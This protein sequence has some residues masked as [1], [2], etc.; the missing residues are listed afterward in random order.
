MKKKQNIIFILSDQHNHSVMS[1]ADDNFINTPNL[2]KLANNGTRFTNAYTNSPLCVPSRMSLLTGKL[3]LENRCLTNEGILDV[4][5]P[6]YAH[7]INSA[8]YET[9]LSGRMHIY[10]CDQYRGN[11]KRLV[12]DTTSLN[13]GYDNISC[14]LGDK[15][16]NSNLQKIECVN[17]SGGGNSVVQE[18]DNLVTKK[19][20]EFLENRTDERPLMLTVGFYAP[21]PPFIADEERF[22]YFYNQLDDSVC[23]D[24]FEENIHPAISEWKRRRGVENITKEEF[25]RMRAAY[26]ANVEMLDKNIGKIIDKAIETLDNTVF[27]YT[28]D[29]GDSMGIN[30]MLWKTTFFDSSVKIPMI[31]SGNGINN[32]LVNEPV[33]LA[34]ITSTLIDLAGA[35]EL[36]ETYGISLKEVLSSSKKLNKN[37]SIISQ[38]GTYG[39]NTNDLDMPSA[40]IQKNGFKLISFYGYKRVLLYNT[41]NDINCS[42]DLSSK[43]EYKQIKLDLL[44]ELNQHWNEEEALNISKKHLENFTYL[45]EWANSTKFNLIDMYYDGLNEKF[46]RNFRINK[47]SNYINVFSD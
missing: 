17:N 26:Y 10:G 1:C 12:G 29:H 19:T 4:S 37:R 38:L 34:D 8:G 23:D 3:P 25:K 33:C 2:D 42:N 15:F 39:K 27:I 36:P 32:G 45:K 21:H 46:K 41:D 16:R 31:I 18:Y 9:V 14:N 30:N 28:S 35:R 24:A 44:E 5:S 13:L 47:K 40:M 43:E 6:T 20:I 22:R 11:E 7:T